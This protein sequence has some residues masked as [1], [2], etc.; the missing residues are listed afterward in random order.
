MFDKKYS[1]VVLS[2]ASTFALYLVE[3]AIRFVLQDQMVRPLHLTIDDTKWSDDNRRFNHWSE[4]AVS[5]LCQD[6]K[7]I[8]IEAEI[9]LMKRN[10]GDWV[11]IAGIDTY[12][13]RFPS[14]KALKGTYVYFDADHETGEIH[15]YTVWVV[16]MSTEDG[17]S[18]DDYAIRE[19]REKLLA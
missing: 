19:V 1:P 15:R 3:R 16:N 2:K 10:D 9:G 7:V 11:I 12:R 18:S 4:I 8:E 14:C 13:L 6:D 5:V 17:N